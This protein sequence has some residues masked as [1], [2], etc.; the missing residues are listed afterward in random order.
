MG[1]RVERTVTYEAYYD[2]TLDAGLL[3]YITS[4]EDP[5]LLSEELMSGVVLDVSEVLVT[6]NVEDPRGYVSLDTRLRAAYPAVFE[7][8]DDIDKSLY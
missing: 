7:V 5:V 3:K 2:A 4:T 1:I 6:D 8:L